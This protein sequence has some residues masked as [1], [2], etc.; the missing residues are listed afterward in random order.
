MRLTEEELKAHLIQTD[1]QFRRLA[2]EHRRYE[3]RLQELASRSYLTPQEELEEI[4]L[5]KL[6]LRLKDQMQ[7]MMDRYRSQQPA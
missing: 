1:E 4:Q 2:A 3:Q 6:K 7:Q 5:K